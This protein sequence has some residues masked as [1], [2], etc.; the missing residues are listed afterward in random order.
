MV[1]VQTKLGQHSKHKNHHYQAL[2]QILVVTST[3]LLLFLKHEIHN[4]GEIVA[5]VSA[6]LDLQS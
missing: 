6:T 3:S 2:T 1:T 5:S 4:A